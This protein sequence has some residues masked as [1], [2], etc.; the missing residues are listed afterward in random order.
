M[1]EDASH[2]LPVSA[3]QST[4][5]TA[6]LAAPTA[7]V[8]TAATRVAVLAAM[9][10]LPLLVWPRAGSAAPMDAAA[11]ARCSSI[12]AN[13]ARLACYDALARRAGL[14]A[15]AAESAPAASGTA[16]P[17]A[18]ASKARAA[19]AA[20]SAAPAPAAATAATAAPAPP[21]SAA[22][23]AGDPSD[24]QNFGLSLAQQHLA[25]AGVQSIAARIDAL[26][27]DQNNQTHVILDNGQSWL[28]LDGDGWVSQGQAVTIKRAALGSFML[29]T[30][31]HH[32]YRV[33][34]LR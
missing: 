9:V 5:A 2:R 33:R 23:P 22:A 7:T 24:P 26:S 4:A 25:F 12:A 32:S 29:T 3:A 15:P 28:L 17:A 11:L 10:L 27:T 31:S 18:V 16:S 8:P 21:A 34:R 19:P 6:A 30:P 20:P 1:T 13:D 14:P